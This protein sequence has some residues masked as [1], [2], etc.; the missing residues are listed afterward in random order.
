MSLGPSAPLVSSDLHRFVQWQDPTSG[1][2]QR[3]L[4]ASSVRNK[5]EAAQFWECHRAKGNAFTAA[6]VKLQVV[7]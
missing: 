3:P 6:L 5:E 2:Q 1:G 7:R 4:A